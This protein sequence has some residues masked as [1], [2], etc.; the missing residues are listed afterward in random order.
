MDCLEK[1]VRYLILE[2]RRVL[3][4]PFPFILYDS[5]LGKIYLLMYEF[6]YANVL[7][8]DWTLDK[9]DKFSI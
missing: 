1:S 9:I 4:I 2:A 8:V 7:Q 6:D 3:H 5:T